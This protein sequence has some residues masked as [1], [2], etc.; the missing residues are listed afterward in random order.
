M[1]YMN[2]F[3]IMYIC[4]FSDVAGMEEAKKEVMEFVDYLQNPKR[5]SDLGARIPKV[6]MHTCMYVCMYVCTWC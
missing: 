3:I 6:R 4:R 5:Y 2:V 1:L